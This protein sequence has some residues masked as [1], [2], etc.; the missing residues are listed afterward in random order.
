MTYTITIPHFY[1]LEYSEQDKIMNVDIDFRDSI[2]YLNTCIISNWNPPHDSIIL[3]ENEKVDILNNI[4]N[5]LV[6]IRGFKNVNLKCSVLSQYKEM[7]YGYKGNI[8][9]D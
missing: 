9:N 7:S 2:I 5:Y 8:Q 4:Y 1:C 3:N 6:N